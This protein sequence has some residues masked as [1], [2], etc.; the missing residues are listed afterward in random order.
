[1][2][3]TA[4]EIIRDLRAGGERVDVTKSKVCARLLPAR[5]RLVETSSV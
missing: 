1:M 2:A 3:M 4:Q 5:R